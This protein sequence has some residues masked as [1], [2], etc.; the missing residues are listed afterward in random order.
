MAIKSKIKGKIGGA[1]VITLTLEIDQNNSKITFLY[2]YDKSD[3]ANISDAKV[4][5]IIV[6]NHLDI[7]KN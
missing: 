4:I 5:Q 2:V 3:M 6:D 1:L 7:S